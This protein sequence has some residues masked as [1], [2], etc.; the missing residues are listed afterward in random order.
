MNTIGID[1]NLDRARIGKL[2]AIGLFG[3][4]LTGAGDFLLGYAEPA[5]VAGGALE[6]EDPLPHLRQVVQPRHRGHSHPSA[7]VPA[8]R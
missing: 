5:E 8:R 7:V 6:A 3:C 2:L 1:G 4:A